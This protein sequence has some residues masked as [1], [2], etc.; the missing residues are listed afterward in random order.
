MFTKW[1]MLRQEQKCLL[2]WCHDC[3]EQYTILKG[4]VYVGSRLDLRHWCYAFW[5]ASTSNP[6]VAALEMERHC[7]ISYKSAL[8]LMNRIRFATARELANAPKL[9]GTVQCDETYVGGKICYKGISK[10]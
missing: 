5:G 7:Q 6:R 9:T 2:W 1:Q 8:F 3:G 10:L 4:T